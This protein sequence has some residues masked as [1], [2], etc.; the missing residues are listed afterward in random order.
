[1]LLNIGSFILVI[2]ITSYPFFYI[3][4]H[5]AMLPKSAGTILVPALAAVSGSA[6]GV[7]AAQTFEFDLFVNMIPAILFAIIVGMA[8]GRG[9]GLQT[10]VNGALS[11]LLGAMLGTVAGS[12][13]FKSGIVV[14]AADIAFVVLVFLI[15]KWLDGQFTRKAAKPKQSVKKAGYTGT[16]ML[17]AAILVLAGGIFTQKN[18]IVASSIGQPQSQQAVADEEND[19]QLATIDITAAGFIPGNTELKAGSM[20]KA[21]FNVKPN[22]GTGL[23]LVSKDLNFSAELNEGRNM[24]LLNNPQPGTYD[25]MLEPKGSKCTFTIKAGSK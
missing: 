14:M 13:F 25:I 7:A 21:V 8:G 3:Y 4:K 23:K 11:G 12:L 10:A 18:Q 9:F 20:I 5:K 22:A 19:L 24:F 2:L 17:M 1:M 6:F 16:F 15:Q